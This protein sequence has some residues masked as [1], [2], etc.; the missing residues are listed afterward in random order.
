M[1][2]TKAKIE[3]HVQWDTDEYPTPADGRI[4][5]QLQEDIQDAVEGSMS[6]EINAI[7]ITG[8]SK[9]HDKEDDSLRN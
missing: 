6:I 3:L 2:K 1:S 4:S 9:K 5:L 8:I 7:K